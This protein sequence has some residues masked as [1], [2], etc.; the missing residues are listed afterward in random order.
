VVFLLR[1]PVA[2]STHQRLVHQHLQRISAL[3][4]PEAAQAVHELA[5]DVRLMVEVLAAALADERTEVSRAAGQE[6]LNLV[7]TLSQVP[8]SEG[9]AGAVAL[10]DHLASQ[11]DR[12]S[13]DRRPTAAAIALRLMHWPLIDRQKDA[14]K[15]IANCETILLQTHDDHNANDNVRLASVEQRSE[16]TLAQPAAPAVSQTPAGALKTVAPPQNAA[17]G[18]A[19]Q[20]FVPAGARDL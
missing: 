3:P 18:A 10:A 13:A 14:A 4:G 20:I 19:P 1:D 7:E 5:A 8:H 15:L 6:L 12:I 2:L 17:T 16:T 9:E 11:V